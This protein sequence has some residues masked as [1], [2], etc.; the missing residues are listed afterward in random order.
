MNRTVILRGIFFALA[1]LLL[2][3]CADQAPS[4]GFAAPGFWLGIWHGFII[5]WSVLIGLFT[6]ARIYAFPNSGYWYDVGFVFGAF[7]GIGG[8]LGFIIA[9]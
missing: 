9:T 7:L 8:G 5:L 1:A 6:D 4:G 2:S 3:S